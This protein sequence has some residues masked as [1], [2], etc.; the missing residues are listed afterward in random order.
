MMPAV[1]LQEML[2]PAPAV[3]VGLPANA[4][5]DESATAPPATSETA[6][7]DFITVLNII[8][9]SPPISVT[10]MDMQPPCGVNVTN[11]PVGNNSFRGPDRDG[12]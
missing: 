4:G 9:G 2:L 7:A 8:V 1:M 6:S 10:W 3:M 12:R 11:L 5:V